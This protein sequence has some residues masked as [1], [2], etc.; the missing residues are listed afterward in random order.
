MA[1]LTNNSDGQLQRGTRGVFHNHTASLSVKQFINDNWSISARSSYDER[2]FGAQNFYTTFVS[3]T[4][5]EKVSSNWNQAR[6]NFQKG[7]HNIS[8]DAGYKSKKTSI[9]TILNQLPIITVQI[10]FKHYLL[11]IFK[12]IL[13]Q[14]LVPALRSRTEK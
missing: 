13:K 7:K 6:L 5:N 3:D 11:I 1:L 4:A 12:S 14:L 2:K 10:F 8:L 9:S